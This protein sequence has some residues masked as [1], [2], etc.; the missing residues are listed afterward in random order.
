MALQESKDQGWKW[1]FM[2]HIVPTPV[3]HYKIKKYLAQVHGCIGANIIK[4]SGKVIGQGGYM[5]DG[6]PIVKGNFV[7]AIILKGKVT[8]LRTLVVGQTH[9]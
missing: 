2:A 1:Q 5:L 7:K 3:A 6:Q 9:L 8:T 4:E